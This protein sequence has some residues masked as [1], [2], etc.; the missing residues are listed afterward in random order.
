[1]DSH[2]DTEGLILDRYVTYEF[3]VHNSCLLSSVRD[4][5]DHKPMGLLAHVEVF[6]E[7]WGAGMPPRKVAGIRCIFRDLELQNGVF[8]LHKVF[9]SLFDVS[10]S[11]KH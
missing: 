6:L 5:R 9:G 3:V 4:Y 2:Y 7:G 10:P 11:T 8:V 1:M